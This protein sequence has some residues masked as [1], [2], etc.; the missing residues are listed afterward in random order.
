VTATLTEAIENPILVLGAGELGMT[1]LRS[2]ARRSA[3]SARI[4]VP[5]R[6]STITSND[7]VNQ[8]R[9]DELRSLGVAF[10]G[11]DLAIFSAAQLSGQFATSEPSLAAQAS[12]AELAHRSS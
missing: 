10:L 3:Q 11:G 1:V 9:I 5:L 4:T 8:H 12:S 6:S 7:P 2:L